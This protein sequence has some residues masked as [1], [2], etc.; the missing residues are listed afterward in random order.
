MSDEPKQ[1][2]SNFWKDLN[3][4]QLGLVEQLRERSD[5]PALL[6]L[7]DELHQ[8]LVRAAL[9]MPEVLALIAAA[10]GCVRRAEPRYDESGAAY[11]VYYPPGPVDIMALE[12]ALTALEARARA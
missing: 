7:E 9:E 10:R 2:T 1:P 5:H 11:T 12:S 6:A 3:E 4:R 8:R